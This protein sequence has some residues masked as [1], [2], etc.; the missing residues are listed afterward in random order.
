MSCFWSWLFVSSVSYLFVCVYIWWMIIEFVRSGADNWYYWMYIFHML[1]SHWCLSLVCSQDILCGNPLYPL[2][3]LPLICC[4]HP[5]GDGCF[6]LGV[7][8]GGPSHMA[9]TIDHWNWCVCVK[10]LNRWKTSNHFQQQGQQGHTASLTYR[11]QRS[12]GLGWDIRADHPDVPAFIISELVII[13]PFALTSWVF[14][15]LLR[16]GL[17]GI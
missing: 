8:K 4:F 14:R 13:L 11:V 2:Y 15:W 1:F 17:L 3:T 6:P 16:R 9:I 12:Y 10:H 7:K 5:R